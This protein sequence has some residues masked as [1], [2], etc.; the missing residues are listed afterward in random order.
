MNVPTRTLASGALIL[1]ALTFLI[2][3]SAASA[4]PTTATFSGLASVH[5]V[6]RILNTGEIV[7]VSFSNVPFTVVATA[8]GSGVGTIKLIVP[9]FGMNQGPDP[10][11]TGMIS[12]TADGTSGGGTLHN[13]VTGYMSQEGFGVSMVGGQFQCQNTGRSA[14]VVDAFMS[15]MFGT[16][17]DTIQ[18]D[19]HGA[20]PAGSLSVS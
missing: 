10:V 5:V 19:L 15:G 8:G 12:V 4:S 18:M 9:K 6:V 11:G 7:T 2:P 3:F 13:M 17:V 16:P 1:M 14:R 20:V